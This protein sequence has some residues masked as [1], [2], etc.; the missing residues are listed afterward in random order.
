M[1]AYIL[2]NLKKMKFQVK[3]SIVGQMEK[4][5]RVAGLRT[6][7]MATVN[8]FG[9]TERVSKETLKMINV[10]GTAFSHGKMVDYMMVNGKMENSTVKVF[11]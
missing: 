1:A 2:D 5:M 8:L 11:L 3:V 6:K 4:F 10:K 9:K 7:C